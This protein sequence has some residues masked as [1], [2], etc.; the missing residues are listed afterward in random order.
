MPCAMTEEGVVFSFR[1][2]GKDIHMKQVGSCAIPLLAVLIVV[3]L[4][5]PLSAMAAASAHTS[6]S[7]TT[8]ASTSPFKAI[9]VTGTVKNKA[10]NTIGTF[11][12]T[13]DVSKFAAQSGHLVAKGKLSG[14]LKNTS[15]VV[16]ATITNKAVTIPV[17]F[18]AA[19]TCTILTLVLGPIHLNVLAVCRKEA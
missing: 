18:A 12:G 3:A 5:L 8:S 1:E 14:T 2:K 16:I 19:P 15:G 10:G 7:Y 9:P 13:L 17:S 11:S 6:T 4:L